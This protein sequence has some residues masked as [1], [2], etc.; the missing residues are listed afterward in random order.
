MT[1]GRNRN[2]HKWCGFVPKRCGFFGYY[3]SVIEHL[4]KK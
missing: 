4:L 3:N 2:S 1:S